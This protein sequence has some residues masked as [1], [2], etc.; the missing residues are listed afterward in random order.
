MIVAALAVALVVVAPAAIAQH[1][2]TASLTAPLAQALDDADRA[3]QFDRLS[4]RPALARAR[5][6]L[7]AGDAQAALA[8]ARLAVATEPRFW[9][10][11]QVEYLAA[12][13]AGDMVTARKALHRAAA[14]GT[15]L[16]RSGCGWSCRRSHERPEGSA[17]H[18]SSPSICHGSGLNTGLAAIGSIDR[19]G[20]A[21]ALAAGDDGGAHRG[22]SLASA[23]AVDVHGARRWRRP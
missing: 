2:L 1:Y 23:T 11:W 14:A 8:D 5:A 13:R 15:A 6:E 3:A 9:V 21:Q 17:A 22:R 20:R 4:S 7:A 18:R 16:P 10:G 12:S 19:L